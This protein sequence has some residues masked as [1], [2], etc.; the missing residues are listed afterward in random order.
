MPE[1]RLM[2]DR[3]L[4]QATMAQIREVAEGQ[5]RIEG[6]LDLI[7]QDYNSKI[8]ALRV[9]HEAD[10]R[11]LQTSIHSVEEEIKDMKDQRK[12]LQRT[13]IGQV[14]AIVIG[15]IAVLLKIER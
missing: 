6:K 7:S 15:A 11:S 12:W 13:I 10:V 3:E 4:L 1:D 9:R 8:E 14:I 2:D 5:I